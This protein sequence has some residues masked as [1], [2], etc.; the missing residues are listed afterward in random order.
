[1][2]LKIN[3]EKL[4][5]LLEGSLQGKDR[6][7]LVSHLEQCGECREAWEE[8]QLG[9]R[10][11]SAIKI[12][13]VL[14]L[15]PELMPRLPDPEGPASQ[16]FARRLLI[17]TL[18]LAV[19]VL[20]LALFTRPAPTPP[21]GPPPT[22]QPSSPAIFQ[23]PRPLP[24]PPIA[25]VPPKP[26]PEAGEIGNEVRLVR[27]PGRG[28]LVHSPGSGIE[29]M[30]SGF[31]LKNGAVWCDLLPGQDPPFEVVCG[32]ARIVV[33]GTAFG[34][35]FQ[36]ERF[37]VALFRGKISVTIGSDTARVLVPGDLL[38][39]SAGKATQTR[40]G[41]GE[42][43]FWSSLARKA[44]SSATVANPPVSSAPTTAP[45]QEPATATGMEPGT[46]DTEPATS[47]RDIRKILIGS[48]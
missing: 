7:D 1:M 14:N 10:T 2:S 13:P 20:A 12:R 27:L 5:D 40:I 22:R 31:R 9:H 21:P 17:P 36:D 23:P 35:R 29:P 38:A 42:S 6:A 39:L 24:A 16:P 4:V 28:T 26:A 41:R 45:A 32:A 46:T 37:E 18:V 43:A 34:V 48:D 25:A 15:V 3:E 33:L 19:V 11:Y 30:A 8:M 47:S 44:G